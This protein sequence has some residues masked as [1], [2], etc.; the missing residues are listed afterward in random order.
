LA[1]RGSAEFE[2]KLAVGWLL[3]KVLLHFERKYLISNEQ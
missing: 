3:I 1:P 2:G